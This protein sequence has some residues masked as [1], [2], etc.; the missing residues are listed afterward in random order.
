MDTEKLDY[1]TIVTRPDDVMSVRE[2]V[3]RAQRNLPIPESKGMYYTSEDGESEFDDEVEPNFE[4][5][6]KLD[7]MDYF[8]S[9][10]KEVGASLKKASEE[11]NLQ[12][13]SADIPLEG[14]SQDVAQNS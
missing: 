14:K 5:M 9:L 1:N 3:A 4:Y 7:S 6:D 2:I 11:R 8:D 10:S 12:K 13:P